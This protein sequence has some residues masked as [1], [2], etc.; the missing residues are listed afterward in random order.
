MD[1]EEVVARVP[2]TFTGADFSAV[3]SQ[4]LLRALKRRVSELEEE[5]GV[6][7]EGGGGGGGEG[8]LSL[9]TFLSQLEP[10]ELVARVRQEDFLEAAAVVTPSVSAQELLHYER[11]KEQFSSSHLPAAGKGKGKEE[12]GKVNG[13][14]K[15]EM[16]ERGGKGGLGGRKV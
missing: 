7:N 13:G 14:G 16:Q 9:I 6:L 3:A 8:R 10:H 2:M 15:E 11:L 5:L 4:A 12:E 1:L